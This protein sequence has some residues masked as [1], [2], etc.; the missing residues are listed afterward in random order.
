MTSENP[1]ALFGLTTKGK[2]LPGMDADFI[3]LDDEDR[4]IQTYVN[5]VCVYDYHQEATVNPR[6]IDQL[7]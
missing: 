7:Q 3:I 4:L 5:G 6:F 2:L 1:A